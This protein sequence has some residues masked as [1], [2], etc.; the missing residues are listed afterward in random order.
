MAGVTSQVVTDGPMV[1][2]QI[3]GWLKQFPGFCR[4][5]KFMEGKG[6]V[7]PAIGSLGI[8]DKN[9]GGKVN[10]CFPFPS[11]GG[12]LPAQAQHFRVSAEGQGNV[13]QFG[14]RFL[15][16]AQFKPAFGGVQV[17]RIGWGNRF[18]WR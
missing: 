18:Q 4:A 1:R 5:L 12:N 6:T 9:S 11:L 17:M 13:V 8:G 14:F 2:K 7:N 16:I 3:S 15:V 10:A